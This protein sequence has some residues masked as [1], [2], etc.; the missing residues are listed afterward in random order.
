[1]PHKAV[2]FNLE[3][4]AREYIS[5][6]EKLKN[7]GVAI[8]FEDHVLDVSHMPADVG[9]D[10]A[11][12][13]VDSTLKKD[14][15]GYLPKLKHIAAL[16]TGFD[17]V[18]L[19]ACA[20]AGVTVS[21]VPSYGENTVAEYAF[22]LILALSRK[23]CDTHCRV[24][25]EG[26]FSLDGLRGFDLA[27]KTIGVVGTG[28]IGQHAV[29]IAKG[30]GMNVTAYDPYPNEKFA[31]EQGLKYLT[32]NDLLAASDI[33][34]L[35]VP[36]MPATHH[37]INKDN[38]GMVKK[39]AY[40]INTARGAVVETDALVSALKSG[41]L[42]GAGLDV[43]EEEGMVKDELNALVGGKAGEHDLKT[44]LEDHV[45]IDMPNVL[46]TPHNAFNTKEAFQR[47]LDT[48]IDNIVAFVNGQ[49]ANL[50]K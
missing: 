43:L 33:I 35:H 9:F 16:S 46:I 15:I 31:E 28:H 34:T 36:Y 23:I 39:G 27:G 12:I 37:L 3:P 49:P 45:L 38:I 11:G 24:R 32:L 5:G 8:G 44:V 47:I 18:D 42:G 4:W 17:H 41:Q 20:A 14:V 2:F 1:M 10:I 48:T 22:G 26:S 19:P 7:A 30:F 13:F 40:L 29:R 50:V 6:N 25:E 21:T